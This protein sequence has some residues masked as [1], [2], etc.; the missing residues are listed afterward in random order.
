M[1]LQEKMKNL[2]FSPNERI[3]LDFI[4]DKQELIEEYSTTMI[5]EETYTSPSILVR[6]SKKLGF[7][8]WNEWKRAF[9]KEVAY[10]KTNFQDIDAN[11]PF[12]HRDPMMNIAS[13]ITQLH[14]ESAK[15]TLALIRH[16]SLQKA[17]QILSN[18]REVK[19]FTISNLT[20]LGQEFVYKLRHIGKKADTN[21]TESM[22]YQEAVMTSSDDC[23]ICISYSGETSSLLETAQ[24]L[25]MNK[26]PL[27]AITSMGEN[28][29]SRIA[30]VTLHITTREKS[31]SK[32]AGFASLESISLILDILYSSLFSVKYHSNYDFKVKLAQKT[33]TR[34]INNQ[35]IQEDEE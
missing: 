16:D 14:I 33:E 20:F 17:V 19:V 23:A 30:D 15:D 8:G 32:I 22:M 10:L 34:Q 27:I 25:K 13:K 12:T 9:L 1:L 11:T 7:N 35:I 31:Y 24:Y 6:I 5:A 2:K 26:V 29:L 21:P 4:I 28:S 18:C 3:V